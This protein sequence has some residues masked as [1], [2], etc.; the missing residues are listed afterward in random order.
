MV[1]PKLSGPKYPCTLLEIVGSSKSNAQEQ[2]MRLVGCPALKR[3][4]LR[5]GTLVLDGLQP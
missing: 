1:I 2:A 5:A 4:Q 3:V